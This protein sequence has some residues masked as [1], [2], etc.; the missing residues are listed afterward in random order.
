[1]MSALSFSYMASTVGQDAFNAVGC[2]VC[3][4]LFGGYSTAL[5]V[6]VNAAMLLTSTVIPTLV[7]KYSWRTLLIVG[8]ITGFV[9]LA[10]L[11]VSLE[12]PASASHKAQAGAV[13][14]VTISLTAHLLHV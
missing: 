14:G 4:T 10:F 9:G 3:G 2:L 11:I 1:M 5:A 8:D 6:I 12:L 7:L 13:I